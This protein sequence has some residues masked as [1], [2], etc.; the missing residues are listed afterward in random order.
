MAAIVN[1]D[2][3]R[4]GSRSRKSQLAVLG[5]PHGVILN[6]VREV[7]PEHFGIVAVDCAKHRSKWMLADFY[8]KVLVEPTVVEH[9]RASLDLAVQQVRQAAVKHSLKDV[10]VCV[11]M[12]GTYHRPVQ[13]AF[14]KAGFETR[15]VHPFASTRYRVV[16][17]GDQKT[18]DN[19]LAAIFR[20]AVNGFGLLEQPVPGIYQELQILSRSRRDLVYKRS[21]LQRQMRHYLEESLPGFAALYDKDLWNRLVPVPFLKL[22]GDRGGT[23]DAVLKLGE[24]GLLEELKAAGVRGFPK[25]S[26]SRIIVWASNAPVSS[27]MATTYARV[28]RDLLDDWSDKTAQIQALERDLVALLVQTPYLLLLS[29]PG[30][31]VVSAAELA[32]EMGPIE[33]YASANSISGRAGLFPSRYQSDE[34]DRTGKLSRYRNAR[35]RGVL[36]RMADS[37][38]KCNAYWKTKS[39]TWK[40]QRVST[41]DIRCR[42]ANRITRAIFQIVS[43]RRLFDHPS[44]LDR[45]YIMQKLL[46]YHHDHRI[47]PGDTV[48]NLETAAHQIPQQ[49]QQE[50]V[51]PLQQF[52]KK[53]QRSRKSEPKILGKLLIAVLARI[54]VRD[55]ESD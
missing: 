7:G 15:L 14:R 42:I 24:Q 40:S 27:E 31:N 3:S 9:Q 35:L 21:T 22:I 44:Q 48:R 36:T 5:K 2:R 45:N 41:C 54:G 29:H 12:T 38:V 18:D 46:D 19:D 43:G 39:E 52:C 20:A 51:R 53:A 25:E 30:I 17:H 4:K 23:V 47:S 32:G 16:E 34:V 8:G 6:R 11:E 49:Y 55:L 1:S 37:L 50:Q 33:N 28:W 10:I 13:R 26:V